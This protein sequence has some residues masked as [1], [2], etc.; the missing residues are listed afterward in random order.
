MGDMGKGAARISLSSGL[1]HLR[2]GKHE[3]EKSVA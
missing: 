2:N 3:M 1:Q